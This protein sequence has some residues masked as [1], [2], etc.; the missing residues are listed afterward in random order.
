MP[1]L[2]GDREPQPRRGFTAMRKQYDKATRVHAQPHVPHMPELEPLTQAVTRTERQRG[3][4][5]GGADGSP[6]HGASYFL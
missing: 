5:G 4:L 2:T 6:I 3:A 1:H